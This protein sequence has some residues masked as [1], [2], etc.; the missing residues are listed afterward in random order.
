MIVDLVAYGFADVLTVEFVD[1]LV[2][3]EFVCLVLEFHSLL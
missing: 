1:Y 3:Y 2:V